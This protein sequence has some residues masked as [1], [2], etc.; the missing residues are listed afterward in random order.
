VGG[1]GGGSGEEGGADG[2]GGCSRWGAGGV[3]GSGEE[4]G[5]DGVGGWVGGSVEEG[6]VH[7]HV[8]AFC[9]APPCLDTFTS[10]LFFLQH[11]L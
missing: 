7:V 8:Y 10:V 4:G 2:V 3:G 1:W 11:T 6:G 9:T 5:A